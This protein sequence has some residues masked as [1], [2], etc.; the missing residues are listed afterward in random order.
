VSWVAEYLSTGEDNVNTA[1]RIQRQRIDIM[2]VERI[3]VRVRVWLTQDKVLLT[4][5]LLA[6]LSDAIDEIGTNL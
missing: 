4:S 2:Y 3:P 1:R 6:R 5:A